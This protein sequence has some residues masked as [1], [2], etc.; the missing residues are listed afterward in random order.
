MAVTLGKRVEG[1]LYGGF[2]SHSL[3]QFSPVAV[4]FRRFAPASPSLA[5]ET[6]EG[7]LMRLTRHGSSN[8]GR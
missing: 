2:E 7:G 4:I 6:H 5:L 1:E 8:R 3:R